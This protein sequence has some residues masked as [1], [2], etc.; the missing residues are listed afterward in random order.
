MTDYIDEHF[1][2]DLTKSEEVRARH[3]FDFRL[4]AEMLTTE[5]HILV[6]LDDREYTEERLVAIGR[7]HGLFIT[8]VYTTRGSRKRIITAWR[9]DRAEIDDYARRMG[10]RDEGKN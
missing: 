1:E 4:V 10:Y 2:W 8:A 6:R 9:S 5:S 7:I 3:G